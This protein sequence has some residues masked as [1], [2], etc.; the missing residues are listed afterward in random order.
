MTKANSSE[1]VHEARVLRPG[2]EPGI[3]A[4]RGRNA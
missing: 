4:L 3:S 2:F 1:F